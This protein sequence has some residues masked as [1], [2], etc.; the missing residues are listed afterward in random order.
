MKSK[1]D[2]MIERIVN[3]RRNNKIC[4][5][6][7]ANTLAMVKAEAV[8]RAREDGDDRIIYMKEGAEL[9]IRL[10]GKGKSGDQTSLCHVRHDGKIVDLL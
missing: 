9:A 10:R 4:T 1:D 6:P 5:I 2:K 8:R 3:R 7:R